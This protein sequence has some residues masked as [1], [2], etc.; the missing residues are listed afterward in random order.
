MVTCRGDFLRGRLGS[1][2]LEHLG[3]PEL[4]AD[5]P[6]AYAA[7]AAEL[8][9]DPLRRLRLIEQIRTA[10]PGLYRDPR[11]IASLQAYLDASP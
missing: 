10:L 3:I 8:A 11:P 6:D 5:S 9:L 1:G 7:V 2:V 4:V